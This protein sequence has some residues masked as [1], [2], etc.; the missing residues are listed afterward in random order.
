M[1]TSH[2][3][4]RG[5]PVTSNPPRRSLLGGTAPPGLAL[6]TGALTSDSEAAVL[7]GTRQGTLPRKVDVV[8][9]GGGISGL[10]A[11]REV[12]AKGR[13]VVVLEARKRVGGR[14]LNH[15]LTNKKHGPQVVESG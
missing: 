15:H 13:S 7:A 9:V 4:T 8:V 2:Q 14:V 5:P 10:V 12:A 1:F 3:R 6:G 11:A